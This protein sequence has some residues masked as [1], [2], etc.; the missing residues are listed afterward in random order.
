M[1]ATHISGCTT[2]KALLTSQWKMMKSSA[3]YSKKSKNFISSIKRQGHRH[4]KSR[5][6]SHKVHKTD[7]FQAKLT[8]LII[9][10]IKVGSL[11][12]GPDTASWLHDEW[13]PQYRCEQGLIRIYNCLRNDI[14]NVWEFFSR[15]DNFLV[16]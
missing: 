5:L 12:N 4:I 16:S 2:S 8:P 11:A 6:Y 3:S 7:A 14:I 9:A 13:K 15:P 10:M 1:P